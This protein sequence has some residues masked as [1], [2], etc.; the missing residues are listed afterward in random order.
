MPNKSR[1]VD[2]YIKSAA[3]F[4]KPILTKIREAYHRAAPDI[5]ET[6]KWN[7]PHF[8]H[9]GIVGSMA[10]FKQHATFGFWKGQLMKSRGA[11]ALGRAHL[12]SVDDLPSDKELLAMVREAVALNEDEV[13][14][15]RPPRA[16]VAAELPL[17]GEL[18]KALQKNAK[19][20][21]AFAEL[22]PSQRNEYAEWISEAKQESTR[23]ERL[24]TAIEW[25]AQ[26]RPR[27]WKYMKTK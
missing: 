6:M 4:A 20:R 12:T 21:T 19:A 3:D 14:L 13:K 18:R 11:F 7:V 22:S 9:K 10:A 25:I 8:E 17:P 16:K 26:G 27:N 1:E 2:A 15:P 24:D 5:E 23:S